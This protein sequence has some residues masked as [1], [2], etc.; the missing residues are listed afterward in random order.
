MG[1]MNSRLHPIT[2]VSCGPPAVCS[3]TCAA[4][5]LFWNKMIE[6]TD[7]D[8]PRPSH[9]NDSAFRHQ[10]RAVELLGFELFNIQGLKLDASLFPMNP[11]VDLGQYNAAPTVADFVG[12]N[13]LDDV[14]I[15]YASG[16]NGERHTF[17]ADGR[18]FFDNNTG[19]LIVDST[20][21][22][23]HRIHSDKWGRFISTSKSHFR[24]ACLSPVNPRTTPAT[25][26]TNEDIRVRIGTKS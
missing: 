24:H 8:S 23:E 22:R 9:L 2:S 25:A 14:V 19:G 10:C 4:A 7:F 11:A 6:A 3:V 1:T 12:S 13:D 17:A 18:S 16:T 21:S 26:R 15:S 5:P 20:G